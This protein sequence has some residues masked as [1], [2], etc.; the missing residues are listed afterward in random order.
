MVIENDE[1]DKLLSECD[2]L[3]KDY[4]FSTST[5]YLERVRHEAPWFYVYEQW[6][7]SQYVRYSDAYREY[8]YFNV[9]ESL[10]YSDKVQ[11]FLKK[12]MMSYVMLFKLLT[13]HTGRPH[14]EINNIKT[15]YCFRL[16][17]IENNKK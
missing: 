17:Y 6:Y 14:K 8:W 9:S 10:Y 16:V 11:R 5:Y 4:K 13:L 3:I 1:I 12:L 15:K 7:Q 2:T